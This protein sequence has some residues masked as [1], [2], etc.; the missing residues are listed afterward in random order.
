MVTLM[1]ASFNFCSQA[2]DLHKRTQV[3]ELV[4][5]GVL[6][7]LIDGGS[8]FHEVDNTAEALLRL[9]HRRRCFG[10]GG[11]WKWQIPSLVMKHF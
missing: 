3:R 8:P 9:K 1:M 7:S 10:S 2:D 5:G 11:R 6:I 4:D